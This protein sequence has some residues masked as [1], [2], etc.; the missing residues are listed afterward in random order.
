MVE[1]PTYM[2]GFSTIAAPASLSGEAG[3]PRD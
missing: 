2:C 3:A 1:K